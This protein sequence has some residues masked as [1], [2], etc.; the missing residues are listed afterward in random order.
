[1]EATM[2]VLTRGIDEAVVLLVPR[3]GQPSL[4][5]EVMV[6]AVRNGRVRIGFEAP[7]EVLIDREE[8]SERRE[9][10]DQG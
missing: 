8:V 5:I 6:T 3:T 7:A 2:L 10:G 1:M 4:R 9:R